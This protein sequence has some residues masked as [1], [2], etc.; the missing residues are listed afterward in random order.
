MKIEKIYQFAI[1]LK[2][3]GAKEVNIFTAAR[4]A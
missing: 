3:H 4:A 1:L 2:E